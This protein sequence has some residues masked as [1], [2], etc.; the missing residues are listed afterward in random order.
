MEATESTAAA[1]AEP[2]VRCSRPSAERAGGNGADGTSS[3]RAGAPD[4]SAVRK[5]KLDEQPTQR[6]AVLVATMGV[7]HPADVIRRAVELS[8]GAPVAVVTIARIYGSSLGL[9][10]PGLMPTRRRW[11]SSAHGDR[12]HR[13]PRAGGSRSAGARWRPPGAT[14][15]PSPR[16]PGPRCRPRAGRPPRGPPLAHSSSRAT[17]PATSGAGSAGRWRWRRSSSE[18]AA[19]G[20][21]DLPV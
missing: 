17:W 9:P 14:P 16:P 5:A 21:P 18:R 19:R 1:A 20:A 7:E 13:P 8:A 11:T 4:S 10:N 2:V 15:R 3:G 12:G 6:A